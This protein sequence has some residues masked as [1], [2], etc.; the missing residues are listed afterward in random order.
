MKLA[1]VIIALSVIIF[2]ACEQKNEFIPKPK[3][4]IEENT[5]ITLMAELQLLDA[6]NFT[7]EDSTFVDSIR[8]ELFEHY[9]ISE[10]Q[11]VESNKYYQSKVEDHLARIDS[12]QQLLKREQEKLN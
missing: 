4:I 12:A 2:G 8:I 5:Y 7:Y 6:L 10:D 1:P 11:F 3:S 9:E